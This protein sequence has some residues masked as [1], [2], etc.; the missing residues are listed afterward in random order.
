MTLLEFLSERL[1]S[2][3]Q[4]INFAVFSN[5]WQ[6]NGTEKSTHI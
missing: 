6:Q 4:K 5:L 3:K 2:I 1:I